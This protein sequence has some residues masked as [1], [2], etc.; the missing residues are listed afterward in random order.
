MSSGLNNAAG[1]VQCTIQN[2][3]NMINAQISLLE[4]LAF[5]ALMSLF[6]IMKMIDQILEIL[7]LDKIV[8]FLQ[9]VIETVTNAIENIA[10]QLVSLL[11]AQLDGIGAD[12]GARIEGAIC[13]FSL[14]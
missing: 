10:N 4:T 11:N 9:Q 5:K 7:G 12:I 13:Q 2:L 8:D 6:D 14:K 1:C 3:E